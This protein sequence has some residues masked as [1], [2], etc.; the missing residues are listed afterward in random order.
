MSLTL[1]SL[2]HLL[3]LATLQQSGGLEAVVTGVTLSTD[4]LV[5]RVVSRGV[6]VSSGPVASLHVGSHDFAESLTLNGFD[7]IVS[8]QLDKRS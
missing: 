5:V 1:V 4:S 8:L 3:I 2:P 7:D 6:V